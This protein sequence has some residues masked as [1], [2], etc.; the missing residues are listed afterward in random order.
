MDE[1][2]QV[3]PGARADPGSAGTTPPQQTRHGRTGRDG[4]SA[5]GESPKRTRGGEQRAAPSR[6]PVRLTRAH[7]RTG[8]RPVPVCAHSADTRVRR[9]AGLTTAGTTDGRAAGRL[10][11]RRALVVT[12][13]RPAGLAGEC[14]PGGYRRA[15]RHHPAG[16]SGGPS[17]RGGRSAGR[18]G[19]RRRPGR[20]SRT[21]ARPGTRRGS[22]RGCPHRTAGRPGG[23][24]RLIPPANHRGPLVGGRVSPGGSRLPMTWW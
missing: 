24:R 19:S 3:E 14:G 13:G 8:V 20:R 9:W 11:R 17:S 18:P 16:T 10:V 2:R 4:G 1:T 21:H 12:R 15:R 7:T 23:A 5:E 6:S 22:R